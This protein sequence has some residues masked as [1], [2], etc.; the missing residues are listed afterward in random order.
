MVTK[1]KIVYT[2]FDALLKIYLNPIYIPQ[3]STHTINTLIM[4]KIVILL[5]IFTYLFNIRDKLCPDI[6]LKIK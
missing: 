5:C 2:I 1:N 4:L 3:F 6:N